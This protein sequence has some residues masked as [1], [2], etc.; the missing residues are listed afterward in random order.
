VDGM[1]IDAN[2]IFEDEL[3]RRGIAFAK[4]DDLTYRVQLD[5]G[6]VTASLGNV[7]RNAERDEDPDVIKRFVDK[8]L[9]NFCSTLPTWVEASD[10]LL[11]A[12]EPAD[13]DFGD[14]IKAVVTDEVS[15]VLT[16]TDAAQTKITWVTR[17][18]CREWGV[19]IDEAVAAAFLNQDR[20]LHGLELELAQAHGNALGMVPLDSPYKASVIFARSFKHLVES[21][22]GWPVLVVLPCRDFIYVVADNS[23]LLNQMGSVVAEEFRNSGYPITTEVLRVSDDGIEAIGHFPP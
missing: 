4:D 9:D 17:A 21:A 10:L 18:T 19:T 1:K 11:W 7:W 3:S 20:L 2:A 5:G 23:P 15:R 14:T 22:L 6:E 16:L 8:L 12:A 13:Q